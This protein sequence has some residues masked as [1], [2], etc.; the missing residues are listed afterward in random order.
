MQTKKSN[1][2]GGTPSK[3]GP[4]NDKRHIDDSKKP[5]KK[6]KQDAIENSEKDNVNGKK[7]YNETPPDVPVKS[8][9]RK[10]E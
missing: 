5:S 9:K 1:V 4:E 2:E 10:A 8:A 7:G 6:V 3:S